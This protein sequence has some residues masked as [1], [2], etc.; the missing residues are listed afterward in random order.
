MRMMK[1]FFLMQKKDNSIID[2]LFFG[3]KEILYYVASGELKEVSKEEAVLI[4]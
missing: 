3:Y 1:I 2:S 4:I